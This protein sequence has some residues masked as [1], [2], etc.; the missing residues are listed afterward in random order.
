MYSRS[1]LLVLERLHVDRADTHGGIGS[2]SI[3]KGEIHGLKRIR[4]ERRVIR[5]LRFGEERRM[6]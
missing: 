5:L 3:E 2:C 6:K 4:E 1:G